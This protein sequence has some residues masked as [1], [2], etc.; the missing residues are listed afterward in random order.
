MAKILNLNRILNN[1]LL[2]FVPALI[3]KDFFEGKEKD[4]NL[5]IT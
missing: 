1:N 5:P 4:T 3:I 2:G